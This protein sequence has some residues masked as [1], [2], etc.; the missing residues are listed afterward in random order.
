MSN[1]MPTTPSR[2]ILSAIPLSPSLATNLITSL[3]I[4]LALVPPTFLNHC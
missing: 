4:R 3:T 2:T 1:I